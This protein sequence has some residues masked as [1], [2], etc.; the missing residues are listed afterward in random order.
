MIQGLVSSLEFLETAIR[1]GDSL[2][3]FRTCLKMCIRFWCWEVSG[4]FVGWRSS[5]NIVFGESTNTGNRRSRLNVWK[6]GGGLLLQKIWKD[7]HWNESFLLHFRRMSVISFCNLKI[8]AKQAINS[9]TVKRSFPRPPPQP[10]KKEKKIIKL[11]KSHRHLSAVHLASRYYPWIRM[12]QKYVPYRFSHWCTASFLPSVFN[13]FHQQLWILKF[14]HVRAVLL[15]FFVS[16][17]I[18]LAELRKG[19][20]AGI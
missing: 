11:T 16:R 5:M 15:I 6:G 20:K 2:H 19:F 4:D 9:L 13:Y 14:Q 10:K 17:Q 12:E 3:K 7:F 1:D 18:F 8:W